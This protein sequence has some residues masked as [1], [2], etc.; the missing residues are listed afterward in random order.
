MA[1]WTSVIERLVDAT[2]GP[3]LYH[4]AERL[5]DGD[6][7]LLIRYLRSKGVNDKF[8]QRI[9]PLRSRGQTQA[10]IERIQKI[11]FQGE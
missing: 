4:G 8:M 5:R 2:Y 6:P 11:V 9:P 1:W 7:E 3:R 10:A